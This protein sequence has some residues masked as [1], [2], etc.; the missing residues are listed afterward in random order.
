[1]LTSFSTGNTYSAGICQGISDGG[2]LDWHLPAM[3]ELGPFNPYSPS[4]LCTPGSTNM[5]DELFLQGIGG[6]VNN[7]TYWSSTEASDVAIFSW[8]RQFGSPSSQQL[9]GKNFTFG[10][11]CARNLAN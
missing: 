11:R 6:L 5:L 9:N 10:I 4:S 7:G 3:C 2:Y 1:M 8:N